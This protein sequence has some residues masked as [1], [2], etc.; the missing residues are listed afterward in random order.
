MKT[1]LVVLVF[2]LASVLAKAEE[3]TTDKDFTVIETIGSIR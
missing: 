1:F 2:V 3:L